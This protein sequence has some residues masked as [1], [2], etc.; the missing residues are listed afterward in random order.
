MSG[1]IQCECGSTNVSVTEERQ[2]ARRIVRCDS[3][4]RR[5]L[6]RY[7]YQWPKTGRAVR[8]HADPPGCEVGR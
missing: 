5:T 2:R 1:H 8:L 4:G 6:Y 7:G 3:C